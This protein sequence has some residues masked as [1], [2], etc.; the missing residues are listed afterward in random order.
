MISFTI[1][2]AIKLQKNFI[3][4]DKSLVYNKYF[5]N[6]ESMTKFLLKEESFTLGD[7]E[8][9]DMEGELTVDRGNSTYEFK[10]EKIQITGEM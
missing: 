2:N 5:I 7:V 10:I 6:F 4:S 1:N 8:F 9:I 3:A